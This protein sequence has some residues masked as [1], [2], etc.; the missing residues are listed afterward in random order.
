MKTI[1]TTEYENN[2]QSIIQNQPLR[3]KAKLSEIQLETN[4]RLSYKGQSWKLSNAGF[5]G[6]CKLLGITKRMD[7]MLVRTF[8]PAERNQFTELARKAIISKK[9]ENVV[10]IIS[11]KSGE[12]LNIIPSARPLLAHDSFFDVAEK[13]IDRHQLSITGMKLDELGGVSINAIAADD[14]WQLRGFK[15]LESFNGGITLTN[16]SIEGISIASFLNRLICSNGMIG[17]SFEDTQHLISTSST[18]ISSFIKGVDSLASRSFEPTGFQEQVSKA[19]STVASLYELEKTSS[20]IRK[21]AGIELFQLE[22]WIPLIETRSTYEDFGIK[23][24]KL[25]A[26]QKKHAKTSMTIWELINATTH[27]AT[28][29]NGMILSLDQRGALQEKAGEL[30]C[31]E[32]DLENNIIGPY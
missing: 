18:N 24:K 11:G 2:K 13:I 4:E 22:N 25:T 3:I 16:S 28:H 21:T 10:L 5:N 27:F 31:K 9:A 6:L 30:L 32:Y 14:T 29:E 15:D 7:T 12:L 8:G 19:S 23:T 20:L 1:T 17:K 26:G